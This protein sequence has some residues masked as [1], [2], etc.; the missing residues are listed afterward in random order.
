VHGVLV[1]LVLMGERKAGDGSLIDHLEFVCL[2]REHMHMKI[3]N[4]DPVT[5]T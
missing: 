2:R 1:V 4:R 3:W 5:T